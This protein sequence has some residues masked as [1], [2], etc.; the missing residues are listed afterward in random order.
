MLMNQIAPQ[1]EV[2]IRNLQTAFESESNAH[3]KFA[4]FA[5]KADAEGLHETARLFRS[6]ALSEQIHA[7]NHARVIRQFGG[8]PEAQIQSIE[9]KTTLDNLTSALGDKLYE[10]ESMYPRF[11][12]ENRRP[13]NSAARTLNWALEAE[14][15]HARLLSEEIRQIEAG[16]A[17]TQ[18]V[19][20]AEFYVRP[21]CGYISKAAEP[22]RCWACDRFCATFETVR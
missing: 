17:H 1:N 7:V 15:T 11:L 13:D 4:A 8:E 6:L 16:S 3:A 19:T 10:I 21:V 18:A 14:K 20:A 12:A 2:T 5:A 9:V 22:E